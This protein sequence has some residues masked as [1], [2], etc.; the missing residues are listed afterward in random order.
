[1]DLVSV[2]QVLWKHK[3]LALP[4]ILLTALAAVYVVR[5]KPPVYE[6]ASTVLL[7]NPPKQPTLAQLAADPG[8]KYANQDNSFADYGDLDIVANAVI[9]LVDSPASQA[10]LTRA[11][12]GTGYQLELSTDYGNPPIIDI[13]GVGKTAEAAIASAAILTAT[14]RQDLTTL[15]LNAGVSPF[16]LIGG[17]NIVTPAQA[18][19]SSSAKLRALVAVVAAGIILL[20]IVVSSADAATRRRRSRLVSDPPVTADDE[21]LADGELAEGQLGDRELADE[22]LTPAP[23]RGPFEAYR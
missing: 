19:R 13:T 3:F 9:D 21:E 1:M 11:G 10:E 14:V 6:A 4:V 22:E 5:I 16:Y 12:A 2:L 15:Q 7:T 17:D 23:V 20:F 18:Q 8:L